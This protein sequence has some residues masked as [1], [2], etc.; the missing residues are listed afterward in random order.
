VGKYTYIGD[1]DW[2]GEV[3]PQDYTAVDANL[4]ATNVAAGLSWFYGDTDFDGNITPQDYTG[5]D[6]GLGLGVGNPLAVAG[7][8]VVPEPAGMAVLIGL[9]CMLRRRRR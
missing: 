4:G 7:G 6:A 3:T 1:T 2:D 9:G 5:I 8:A